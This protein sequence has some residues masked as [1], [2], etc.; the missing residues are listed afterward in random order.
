MI[1]STAI[2]R[3]RLAL[4]ATA[5][6]LAACG[7]SGETSDAHTSASSIGTDA[8]GATVGSGDGGGELS[9]DDPDPQ[10]DATSTGRTDPEDASAGIAERRIVPLDGDVA[11]IVFALGVGD[12]VVATDL[13]ATY[14]PEAEELPK[15]GIYRALS[16][17]PILAFD[18]TVVVGTDAAGPADTI[19]ALRRV[20]IDVTIVERRFDANGPAAKVRDVGAALGLA[21]EASALATEVQAEIDAASVPPS[22]YDAPMRVLALYLRGAN[23]QFVLGSE[24]GVDWVIEAAGGIDVADELGVGETVQITTEA[25]IAAAP[26]A[27]V[28]PLNGLDS[29]GGLD[30]LLA[31]P[32]IAQTPAGERR[33]VFAY[34]DQLL[35]GNGPRTGALIAALV[36][37]LSALDAARTGRT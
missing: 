10:V 6:L 14:P 32:G 31:I 2:R 28:V 15:I 33:A 11:E 12:D 35:L 7:S 37:D 18:P 1:R 24:S 8:P 26:D 16:P 25:L 4:L 20:G 3:A 9:A 27:I 19:D 21:D 36:A 17:E 22:T 23:L 30:A 29:A 13:S 5:A 34:D